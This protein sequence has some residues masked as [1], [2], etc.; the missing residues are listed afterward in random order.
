MNKYSV[1][2]VQGNLQ[3]ARV[4]K[5]GEVYAILH[6]KKITFPILYEDYLIKEKY[7]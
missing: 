2:R 7:T 6:R 4:K 3:T 1:S 5:Y